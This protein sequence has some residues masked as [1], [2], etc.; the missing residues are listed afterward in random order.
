MKLRSG[1]MA[2]PLVSLALSC[3]YHHDRH[4]DDW[5]ED[6]YDEPGEYACSDEVETGVIDPDSP[7]ESEPGIGVGVFVDYQ[8]GGTW[9]LYTTCDTEDSGYDCAFDIIVKPLGRAEINSF[10]Q[11]GLERNDSV[12]IEHDSLRFVGLTALDTDGFSFQTEPGAGISLDVLLDETCGNAYIYWIGDGAIHEGAPSNPF[13]L[14]PA[15]P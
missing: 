14:E 10:A 7:L 13:E 11:D 12:T 9:H 1:W 4:D 15:A 5:Y 2:L 8:P 3:G 6:S